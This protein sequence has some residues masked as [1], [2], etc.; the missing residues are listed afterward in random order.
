MVDGHAKCL[1]PWAKSW[2]IDA[3]SVVGIRQ[4]DYLGA[5]QCHRLQG[6]AR[7][8]VS[9]C[10]ICDSTH[11]TTIIATSK[12]ACRCWATRRCLGVHHCQGRTRSTVISVVQAAPWATRHTWC[13]SLARSRKVDGNLRGAEYA[14]PSTWT[15]GWATIIVVSRRGRRSWTVLQC[16]G[17]HRWRGRTK[18]TVISVVR[19][20]RLPGRCQEA[21]VEGA[22]RNNSRCSVPG[23]VQGRVQDGVEQFLPQSPDL[24]G[25]GVKALGRSS[26]PFS[27]IF[28]ASLTH[29]SPFSP[30][31][32]P[33]PPSPSVSVRQ[34][35]QVRSI[36][37][38]VPVS[39][40][41]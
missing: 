19:D 24:R 32:P 31:P 25:V 20:T 11:W 41:V 26:G 28:A 38:S 15:T 7:L 12:S 27:F 33:L 36:P 8:T 2:A 1:A 4:C 40:S 34:E 37:S 39:V 5:H 21:L 22:R 13:S 10:E 35:F 16:S 6:Q 14:A 29:F 23:S 3:M 17:V 9:L 18:W 30:L